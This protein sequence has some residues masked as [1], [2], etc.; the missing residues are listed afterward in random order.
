MEVQAQSKG[1]GRTAESPSSRRRPVPKRPALKTPT[2]VVVPLGRN[3][4]FYLEKGNDLV[5]QED[6]I[7]AKFFFD[8]GLKNASTGAT[9]VEVN[10]GLKRGQ[11]KTVLFL[12][13]VEAE[14]QG[15]PAEAITDYTKILNLE[16][17]HPVALRR[18]VAQLKLQ[19]VEAQK[20]GDWNKVAQSLEHAYQLQPDG[21]QKSDLIAA[22]LNYAHHISPTNAREARS[23]YQHVLGLEPDNQAA[24][25]GLHLLDS[26]DLQKRA[27]A[28]YLTKNYSEAE[29]LFSEALAL[30]PTNTEAA[31][32]KTLATASNQLFLAE[33]AYQGR[34]FLEAQRLYTQAAS[35]LKDTVSQQRLEELSVRLAPAAVPQGIVKVVLR[36]GSAF[37]IQLCGDQVTTQFLKGEKSVKPK[38][39]LSSPLPFQTYKIKL[40]RTSNN[41]QARIVTQPSLANSFTTD[42]IVEPKN[43][44]GEDISVE[45]EWKVP[46]KGVA[47]W[48]AQLGPGK[49]RL[50]WQGHFVDVITISGPAPANIGVIQDPLPHQRIELKVKPVNGQFSARL[51]SPGTPLNFYTSTFEIETVQPIK[52][53]LAFEWIVR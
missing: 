1:L 23:T 5:L 26:K 44:S 4:R 25:T 49:Y 16:V 28:A 11:E 33:T 48:Q 29:H 14:R 9:S 40:L 36:A 46:M 53:L 3:P 35:V 39:E 51:V 15:K 7:S 50:Q 18:V 21:I 12:A 30:D 43:Q 38:V 34:D 24:L 32:G 17:N 8:E 6:F 52:A 37:R 31:Q 47:Q 45:A 42:I 22:W 19:A 27:Q 20:R 13:A 2:G 10:E 41:A